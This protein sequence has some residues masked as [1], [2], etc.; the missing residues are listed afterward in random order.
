MDER[1]VDPAVLVE[2]PEGPSADQL[3]QAATAAAQQVDSE[4][5]TKGNTR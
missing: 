4:V 2:V 1:K 5:T 3:E